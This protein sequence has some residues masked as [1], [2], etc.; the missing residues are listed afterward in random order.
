[1]DAIGAAN[2]RGVRVT[3]QVAARPIGLLLGLQATISPIGGSATARGID[4]AA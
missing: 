2:A 1:M 3:A 4:A